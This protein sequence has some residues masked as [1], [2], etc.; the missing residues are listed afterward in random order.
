MET[1]DF[2]SKI[3]AAQGDPARLEAL[4]R[5]LGAG[6]VRAFQAAMQECA[7]AHPGDVLFRAWM[8]RLE[9]QREGTVKVQPKAEEG[10]AVWKTAIGLSVL[11]GV[12]FM[13]L[14]Q[15]KPPA[16][17]PLP[18][19]SSYF[20]LGWAPLL[21]IMLMA[22]FATTRKRPQETRQYLVASAIITS[23]VL[24]VG[25]TSTDAEDHAT[26]LM[27]LHAP[28]VIWAVV[29]IALMWK[30]DFRTLQVFAFVK[31]SLEVCVTAGLFYAAG[32]L[33]TALTAGIFEA[34]GVEIPEGFLMRFAAWGMG[35]VPLLAVA[36]V[37]DVRYSPRDQDWRGGI[38]RILSIITRLL[39]P[40]ALLVLIVYIVW[41]IP[42]HFWEPFQNREVLAIY[43][44]TIIAM[45][46]L[47]GYIPSEEH[48]GTAWGEWLRRGVLTG[49]ALTILLNVYAYA[50]V[51]SRTIA[52]GI[53]PN[54]HA[55]LG[56]NMVTLV[57]LCVLITALVRAKGA[58]KEQWVTHFQSA[59][60]KAMIFPVAWAVWVLLVSPLLK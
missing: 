36:S 9:G 38:A 43:N 11:L 33:F 59:F 23:V 45:L 54:R 20:W 34:L 47:L 51:L 7:Q 28:F 2:K 53:T 8:L 46:M 49:M 52:G 60:A 21:G 25:L 3:I 17:V 50:A 26:Q 58:K 27:L 35:V 13:L 29:G 55:V 24:V 30:M 18:E 19:D 56:W 40:L 31:K 22:F 15:G 14:A 41:F 16:P 42:A 1:S 12:L 10:N 5:G 37:Y 6:D 39:L 32:G 4:Y 44:A 48:A 57:M